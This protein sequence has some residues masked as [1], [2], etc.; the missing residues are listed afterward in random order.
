M[1]SKYSILRIFELVF[2]VLSLFHLSQALTPLLLTGGASEGDGVDIT[3]LDLSFNAKISLLIY[4]ISFVLL[5]LRWKKVV[6]LFRIDKSIWLIWLLLLIVCLSTLWSVFPSDSFRYSIYAIGTTSFGLY[7]ATRYTIKEQ[8][9]IFS[10]TFGLIVVL[11]ILFSVALPQYGTMGGVHEGAWRGIYTHKNI[12]GLALVPAAVIFYLRAL[13]SQSIRW[14]FW[15]LLASTVALLVLANSTGSLVNLVIMLAL[16]LFYRLLRWRYELMISAI[17]AGII[18]GIAALLW[19]F[20]YGGLDLIF[21]ALGK[22]PTLTG[23]TDIWRYTWD[24]IQLRPWQGYGLNAFW[25]GLQGPSA[26]VELALT[27]PVAYAHNGYLDMWLGIGLIGLIAFFV[28]LFTAATKALAWL[29]KTNTVEG[30]WPL[31]FLTYILL[32]NVAEGSITTMN[33]H[34]WAMYTATFCSLLIARDN[35]YS[36]AVRNIKRW[37]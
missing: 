19:L 7:L 25:H 30:F 17:L 13:S 12:F 16:C 26:Y 35:I 14:V 34:L 2:T 31:L 6:A 11:S 15:L 22:D 18:A 5:F 3:T 36:P 9:V 8:I 23:R 10:W 32:S 33:N 27:V 24:M 28:G 29:R 1:Q 21:T 20:D 4:F 37:A